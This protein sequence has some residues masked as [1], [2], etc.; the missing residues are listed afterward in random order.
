MMNNTTGSY[1]FDTLHKEYRHQELDRL[2]RKADFFIELEK[3]KWVK[4]GLKS[5]M[6][7]LDLGC[8]AGFTSC[9]IAKI[10]YPGT[11][12]G[13]DFS[14]AM[15]EKAIEVKKS[16]GINNLD[17][18]LVDVYHLNFPDNYFD[19][20][21]AR[22]FFQHLTNPMVAIE[23]IYRVLKP[24]GIFCVFDIDNDWFTI[25]PK[26]ESLTKL[27][28]KIAAIQQSQG[29]DAYVG[30]K[31]WSYFSKAGF[32]KIDTQVEVITSDKFGLK[33]ILNLLSFGSP[34]YSQYKDLA[35]FA[36]RAKKDTYSL[37]NVA[38]AWAGFGIFMVTGCKPD[39]V[40]I[41]I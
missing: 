33:T 29:G 6:K 8:G 19:F 2:E 36:E 14:E 15:L 32:I 5:G 28:R 24:G 26:P 4:A 39:E 3:A 22:F 25:Y 34:Y 12:I 20:I 16:K 27:A 31:L 37:I 35:I 7:A 11:V 41:R 40:L 1:R 18:E 21:H 10:T 17:L 9:E 23:N 38:E 30:R 13:V